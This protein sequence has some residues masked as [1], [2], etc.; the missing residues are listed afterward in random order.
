MNKQ[1]KILG[2]GWREI[3]ATYSPQIILRNIFFFFC[4]F[5]QDS[6]ILNVT[7]RLIG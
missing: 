3:Q 5:L 7:Q 4:L 6:V 2:D 1:I